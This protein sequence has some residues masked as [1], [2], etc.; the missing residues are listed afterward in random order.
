MRKILLI[1]FVFVF[2]D[3]NSCRSPEICT[4]KLGNTELQFRDM[5]YFQPGE[6]SCIT[7][8]VKGNYAEFSNDL[9]WCVNVV[10][11]NT[12][13]YKSASGNQ[14]NKN[15]IKFKLGEFSISTIAV[16]SYFGLYD[17]MLSD[18]VTP[19][20]NDNMIIP[21]VIINS[22]VRHDIKECFPHYVGYLPYELL[23]L[24][25]AYVCG[26]ISMGRERFKSIKE[27][28]DLKSFFEKWQD[29][30]N[31]IDSNAERER[32][33]EMSIFVDKWIKDNQ[34]AL[35]EHGNYG[36]ALE[37][38]QKVAE[39]KKM[40]S[41]ANYDLKT[42]ITT[43]EYQEKYSLDSVMRKYYLPCFEDAWEKHAY[44][45]LGKKSWWI[46]G[47]DLCSYLYDDALLDMA[48]KLQDE[49]EK[50]GDNI[51]VDFINF[52]KA[53]DDGKLFDAIGYEYTNW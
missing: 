23:L 12:H 52:K 42:A 48:K 13:E 20:Q 9:N 15:A 29:R 32:Y 38:S 25:A 8:F 11:S 53:V 17:I 14:I 26:D 45:D 24:R 51:H 49:I 22:E 39:N 35:Q 44:D 31:E 30:E 36:T 3:I 40:I 46:F 19:Q 27:F 43:Q 28:V 5:Q 37:F 18:I 33:S 41:R 6:F 4:L 10:F 1:L 2:P 47:S 50:S 34:I 16:N 21:E 7:N